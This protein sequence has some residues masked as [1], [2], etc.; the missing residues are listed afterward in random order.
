MIPGL[1]KPG[2]RFSR[3][4]QINSMTDI[5]KKCHIVDMVFFIVLTKIGHIDQFVHYSIYGEARDTVDTKFL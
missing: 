1:V 5:D 3:L 2:L 4:V